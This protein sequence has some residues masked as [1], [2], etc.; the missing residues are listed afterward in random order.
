MRYV[1][2]EN[3]VGIVGVPAD[4][5]MMRWRPVWNNEFVFRLTVPV[6]AFL[7]VEVH[8]YDLPDNGDF[9]G[10]T[11]LPVSEIRPGIRAV[12][13]Y[14]REGVQFK[15]VRLIVHFELL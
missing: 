11:C 15:F 5:G 2:W 13:V 10:Q 1:C 14:N 3:Q 4:T 12:P 8:E 9:A 6:L 7:L